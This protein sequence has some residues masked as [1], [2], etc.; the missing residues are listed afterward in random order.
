[1][2]GPKGE[3]PRFPGRPRGPM[4][5]PEALAMPVEKARDF[6]GTVK[7]LARHL[8][9]R[10]S[11]M[12]LALLFSV[13]GAAFAILSPRIMGRVTT[14]LFET[15]L[16]GASIDFDYISRILVLLAT[17]YAVSALFSYLQHLLMA[18]VAQSTVRS[19]RRELNAKL[20][21][22]PLRFFDS[23][24]H[25]EILSRFT[26]DAD[27]IA[28]ML[29]QGLTQLGTSLTMM[30]GVM[31]MMLTISPVLT[32]VVSATLP[33]AALLIRKVTRRSQGHFV[34]QQRALGELSGHVE[35][36]YAGHQ[37]VK[38]FGREQL[39][40]DR[41]D[42]ING[43]LYQHAW[44]AQFISGSIM[45]L[46][47]L[48][49]NACFVMVCVAGGILAMR[50]TMKLGD[51]QA[52]M[53]YSRHFTHPI[54]QISHMANILQSA[55]ASAERIF[56]VLDE[57]EEEPD[58][59]GAKVAE[60]PRGRV[61]FENVHFSY[62]EHAPLI[63]DVSIDVEPGQTIA[64]VGPT[65]AGKTTLVNLL[66]RFYETRAGRITVD[67]VDIKQMSRVHL[68][69]LFGM[70]LQDAWLFEGTIRENI[71]YGREGA[72]EEEILRA[73]Q[74]AQVDHFARTLP[75]GYDTVISEGASNLSQG[76][77]Q[78][79]TIARAILADPTI[80]ILDEATS[81]VDTRTE[82]QIQKAMRN[83]MR[84]RTSFVIAHRL[85]T[86][87]DADL[88]LVMNEGKIVEQG[89]HGDLLARRG[90]YAE[91]YNSQFSASCPLKRAI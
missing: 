12:L 9:P 18:H 15:V 73:A 48:I 24:T 83:L 35:E 78:L 54:I 6:R 70:V 1:M 80:L 21:R 55:A 40:I 4:R 88:I 5:G 68:R 27:N 36:M 38:A 43:K 84:G 8:R 13:L 17:L 79:L 67:G 64:I 33:A 49:N 37:V 52:F 74:A 51:V 34:A 91:L 26:N 22:L 82:L 56:E 69:S 31:V 60:S 57:A 23:R 44:K 75:D 61:K 41:F 77:M 7:R 58:P 65:G 30:I 59:A 87:R 20:A 72:T 63:E 16:S 11:L 62:R 53:Y 25:G 10:A 47:R 71:A 46:M 42:E 29:Q 81:S 19:M 76:Q 90:F 86:V 39:A 85:S 3:A 32:L 14:H 66:M 28:T 2:S 50:G 45:P 89:R